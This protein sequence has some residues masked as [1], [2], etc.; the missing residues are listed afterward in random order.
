LAYTPTKSKLSNHYRVTFKSDKK[1]KHAA[2]KSAYFVAYAYCRYMQ[3]YVSPRLTSSSPKWTQTPDFS[4]K[5]KW[6]PIFP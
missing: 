3:A 6:T 5:G 1:L 2:F 4:R